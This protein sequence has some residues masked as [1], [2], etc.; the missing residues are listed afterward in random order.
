VK[1]KLITIVTDNIRPYCQELLATQRLYAEH[2]GYLHYVVDKL[3]WP[4]LHPSFSK[5]WEINQAL[6][7]GYE[8]FIW[9]DADVAFM[10]KHVELAELLRPDYFLAAYKQLNWKSWDYLC[11]GLS[12]WRNCDQAVSFVKEWLRRVEGRFMKD[13]PW[14]QWYFD[15]LIRETSYSGIRK[16]TAEEIG[17]F[18]TETWHDGNIWCDG[19]PTV[20]FAGQGTTWGA[21]QQVFRRRYQELVK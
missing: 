12:V 17:C 10:N 15:E 11:C 3:R 5:V 18:G 14:E 1:K 19:M 9:A 16:C 21:R 2:N 6:E 4:D 13:H 20:H 8:S 7:E